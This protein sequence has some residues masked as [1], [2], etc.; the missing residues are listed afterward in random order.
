MRTSTAQA[1]ALALMLAGCA[2]AA[3]DAAPQTA[4]SQPRKADPRVT[5]ALRH[6]SSN[7]FSKPQRTLEARCA[8]LRG[9]LASLPVSAT[10]PTVPPFEASTKDTA[11]FCAMLNQGRYACLFAATNVEAANDCRR[12]ASE[13]QCTELAAH[14]F[15]LS[16]AVEPAMFD[17]GVRPTR[18]QVAAAILPRCR[19][20]ATQA[21]ARCLLDAGT[22][23]MVARCDQP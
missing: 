20:Q 3:T 8:R 12:A 1:L 11:A 19:Q 5:E 13:A 7:P 4:S 16:Q 2:S 15:D 23:E 10:D 6:P 17:R 14:V 21:D 18:D 9:H 22:Y